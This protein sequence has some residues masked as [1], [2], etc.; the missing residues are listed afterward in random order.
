MRGVWSVREYERVER[1]KCT[2][3]G[4]SAKR[5]EFVKEVERKMCVECARRD[6]CVCVCEACG[7][8]QASKLC[9][10]CRARSEFGTKRTSREIFCLGH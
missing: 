5:G 7:I 10:T 9:N 8:C 6:V 1:V 3:P 4:E 2:E